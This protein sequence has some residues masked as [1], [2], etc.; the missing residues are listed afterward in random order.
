[1]E[2][3]S[4]K[5]AHP[6]TIGNRVTEGI[7][8]E[9]DQSIIELLYLLIKAIDRKINYKLFFFLLLAISVGFYM[10]KSHVTNNNGLDETNNLN[11]GSKV[12]ISSNINN[13]IKDADTEKEANKDENPDKIIEKSEE[14]LKSEPEAEAESKSDSSGNSLNLEINKDKP[15]EAAVEITSTKPHQKQRPITIDISTEKSETSDKIE[16]VV[17]VITPGVDNKPKKVKKEKSVKLKEVKLDDQNPIKKDQAEKNSVKTTNTLDKELQNFIQTKISKIK[18]KKMW[19]PIP[20]SNGGHRRVPSVDVKAGKD[21][22]S[23]VKMSLY[24]EFLTKEECDSLIKVH[25]EHVK[26]LS[27]SKPIVCFD[28]IKTLRNNLIELGKEKIAENVT[29]NDFIEGTRC[30]N[31]TFS[32]SLGKWGLKWSFSTAFY[33]GE[34]KFSKVF[35]NRIE[36]ATQLNETHGG[37]FQ[38]TSYP[39]EIGY[40]SHT[41]CT[42]DGTDE[43]DRYAT[44]LVYLNDLNGTEGGETNFTRLGIDVK[45]KTGRALVWNNINYESGKCEEASI[46]EANKVTKKKYI[47]QRWY[48]YKN[49]FSLGK[50]IREPEI[51]ERELNTP[52]IS[53]DEDDHGSCRLYDEWN[54]DHLLE[55]MSRKHSLNR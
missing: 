37:K 49:Y 18:T 41:D 29:P 31:Q 16:P 19:I 36:E 1:M 45:P 39:P 9:A 38:I 55:Y 20:G 40:K 8:V 35:G 14:N 50:R 47:I 15:K 32:R 27:S 52:R 7:V 17:T 54:Y 53:C 48:Y 12:I 24:E 44:F 34:S 25:E 5:E 22:L 33:P 26:Q 13:L 4:K 28:S 42:V 21:H 10:N 43:R 3:S 23:S 30:I 46:H 11:S 6:V 2:R 51:P